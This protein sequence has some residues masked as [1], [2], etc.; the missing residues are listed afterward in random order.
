VREVVFAVKSD[1]GKSAV[2]SKWQH[3]GYQLTHNVVHALKLLI[4]C[5]NYVFLSIV[6]GLLIKV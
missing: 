1:W 6:G 2:I 3:V 5:V 4:L